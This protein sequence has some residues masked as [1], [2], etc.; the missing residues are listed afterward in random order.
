VN[1]YGVRMVYQSSDM[2]AAR[3]TGPA[4]VTTAPTGPTIVV[5]SAGASSSGNVDSNNSTKGGL[6]TGGIVAI[7]VVIP[8][9]ALV[10]LGAL[11]LWRKRRKGYKA[12]SGQAELQAND[13]SWGTSEVKKGG[14]HRGALSELPVEEA[15]AE[16]GTYR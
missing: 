6:S 7:A 1:A 15:P 3:T 4:T 5:P 14:T 2:A 12:P 13:P 11:F 16:L 9:V 8:V 10:T